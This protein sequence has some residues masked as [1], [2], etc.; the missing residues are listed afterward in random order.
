[1]NTTST[2]ICTTYDMAMNQVNEDKM[3]LSNVP[4]EYKS[5]D[6]SFFH[7]AHDLKC[8]VQ[9]LK[10]TCKGSCYVVVR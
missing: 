6:L 5:I 4:W 10:E 7:K 1:M 9:L 3:Q 2:N 8:L